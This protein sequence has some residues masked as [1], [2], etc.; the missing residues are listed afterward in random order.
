LP[1]RRRR[2]SAAKLASADT[3]PPIHPSA[4]PRTRAH[5]SHLLRL[6]RHGYAQTATPPTSR[7]NVSSSIASRPA[8]NPGNRPLGYDL[9]ARIRAWFSPARQPLSGLGP[10]RVHLTATTP[11]THTTQRRTCRPSSEPAAGGGPTPNEGTAAPARQDRL[12]YPGY[13]T[14]V[15][16]SAQTSRTPDRS[17]PR[18][19]MVDFAGRSIVLFLIVTFSSSGL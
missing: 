19:V 10:R 3:T 8:R 7:V 2:R 16:D 4:Q 17:P 5:V 12:K 15:E 11:T 9:P 1:P 18:I 13:P 14:I 6:P